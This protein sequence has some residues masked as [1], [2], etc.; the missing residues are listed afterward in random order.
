M[1]TKDRNFYRNLSEQQKKDFS[2]WLSMRYAS[3]VEGQFGAYS[4]YAVNEVV[5]RNFHDLRHHPEL[6]WLLL[7]AV[8]TGKPQKHVFIAPGK[9]GKKDK[10]SEMISNMYPHFKPDE[11]QLFISVN[12]KEQIKL[13][14]RKHGYSDEE[15][16]KALS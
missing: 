16:K 9:R 11:I 5:N 8:A 14:A 4:L 10:L 1:D 3:S 7:T 2:A 6:Q 15:I 12:S 13:I